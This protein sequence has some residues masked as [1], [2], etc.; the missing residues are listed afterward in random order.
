MQQR[1]ITTNIKIMS[2]ILSAILLGFF[3]VA[4]AAAA[5]LDKSMGSWINKQYTVKGEWSIE[6]R[7]DQQV[8]T[9]NEKFKTKKGPDLK[10]F[11]S[12]RSIKNVTGSN[13]T[14]GSLLVSALKNNKGKQEYV[15][16]AG[17]DASDYTSLLIHCEAYSVLWGGADL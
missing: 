1:I 2:F 17:I 7:G 3:T 15:L 10:V 8:I 4:V 13:A 5:P 9:F 14:E 12:K 11:L 16:P 6:Q